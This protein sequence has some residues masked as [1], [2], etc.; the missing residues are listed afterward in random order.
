MP[1]CPRCKFEY[2]A[3]E[4]ICPDCKE[5]LKDSIGD[6]SSAA[7]RP[8]DSWVVVGGVDRGYESEVAKGSLDSSNIPSVLMPPLL[9]PPTNDPALFYMSGSDAVDAKLIMVPREFQ[10]EAMIILR[11][12]LGEDFGEPE[13]SIF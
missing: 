11:S 5:V 2:D 8:D 7:R 1:F 4:L 6:S 9:Q 12:V 10:E 3:T 13:T